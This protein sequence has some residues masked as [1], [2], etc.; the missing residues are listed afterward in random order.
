MSHNLALKLEL[1]LFAWGVLSDVVDDKADD[2]DEE[3]D[4]CY[5]VC[6]DHFLSALARSFFSLLYRVPLLIAK[7][8]SDTKKISIV[9][10]WKM[11]ME[12]LYK[13]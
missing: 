9:I 12:S 7:P 6:W 1:T 11:F 4:E 5:D 3:N 8:M 2:R 13:L 10:P